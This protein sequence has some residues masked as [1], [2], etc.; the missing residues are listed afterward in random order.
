[1]S[2]GYTP[3]VVVKD[4]TSDAVSFSTV[5]LARAPATQLSLS[6][7]LFEVGKSFCLV[8]KVQLWSCDSKGTCDK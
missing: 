7:L 6:H 5:V 3:V 1:M 2:I 8:R 4:K